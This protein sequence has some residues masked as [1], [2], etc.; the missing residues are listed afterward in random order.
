M[1]RLRC[2]LLPVAVVIA[3]MNSPPSRAETVID[4]WQSIKAPPPPQLQSVTL[5]P[6]TT[7][8]LLVDIVRQTCNTERR[9]RCIAAVPKIQKLLAEARAKGVYVIYALFPSPSPATFPDPKISDYIPELA[10]QGNEPVVTAFVD[11][12]ILRDKDTG[13]Q[14][15]LTEHGIKTLVPVGVAS[16]NG[17]LFTSVSAALRGFSV[18]VPVD[19]MAGNNAYEDQAADYILTSSIVYKVTPTS[20]GMINF[21]N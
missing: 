4:E 3:S 19:G 8:L 10:P 1:F 15:L 11:K 2:L 14:K 13:L 7:A 6:K 18:V 17:V 9:P 21:A 20:I 5:D 12:F 16:H